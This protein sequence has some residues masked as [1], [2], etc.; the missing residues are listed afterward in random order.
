MK[1]KARYGKEEIKYQHAYNGR[2]YSAKA[3]CC[4]DRNDQNTKDI[5]GYNVGLGKAQCIK[6][7]SNQGRSQ[8][9]EY[10]LCHI[11]NRHSSYT[12]C[13]ICPL[14]IGVSDAGIWDHMDIQIGRIRNQSLCQ[15]RFAENALPGSGAAADY[16]FGNTGKPCKLCNL[17]RNILTIAGFDM[18]AKLLGQP[19]IFPQPLLIII[20]HLSSCRRFHKESGKAPTKCPCHSCRCSDDL[21][22]GRRR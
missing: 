13:F 20:A 5:Y 14:L 1:G 7:I 4:D 2:S 6:R 22:V 12:E 16:Y 15:G 9:D 17:I 19:H 21:C 11:P 3:I 18:C 10:A 8:Q